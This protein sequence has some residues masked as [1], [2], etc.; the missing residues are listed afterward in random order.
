MKT[1]LNKA[2]RAFVILTHEEDKLLKRLVLI[3]DN[4]RASYE[5]LHS[6]V[7][8]TQRRI[9]GSDISIL[10]F[11]HRR[12]FLQENFPDL[13]VIY[14]DR[15]IRLKRYELAIQMFNLRKLNYSFVVL[16][17]LDI[18]PVV[19]SLLFMG[20]HLFLYN[21]WNEWYLLRFKNL[22]EFITLS[23]G[24]DIASFQPGR[25]TFTK[26]IFFLLMLIAHFIVFVYLLIATIFILLRKVYY[27]LK[28]KLIRKERA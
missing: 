14:P 22:W 3:V 17:S 1:I 21:R 12:K 20:S 5:H 8:E 27:V 24:A 25:N 13:K 4:G 26:F 7:A 15:R 6:I 23:R 9:A 28:F 18:T 19:I 11:E 2:G 16:M 10:T